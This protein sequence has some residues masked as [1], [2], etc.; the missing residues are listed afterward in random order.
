MVDV[1]IML[2]FA[3]DNAAETDN[4]IGLLRCGNHLR[5]AGEFKCTG[6]MHYSNVF[7]FCARL[8]QR[9][10][11]TVKQGVCDMVIVVTHHNAK[12]HSLCISNR[13]GIKVREVF[14]ISS[15]AGVG[16]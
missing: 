2:R 5:P 4:S 7:F 11:A 16:C 10:D 12:T 8:E 9:A 1:F 13:G 15:H 14:E 6:H 3:F